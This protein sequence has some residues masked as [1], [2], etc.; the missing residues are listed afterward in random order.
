MTEERNNGMQP[1]IE[2]KLEGNMVKIHVEKD[3]T[4]SCVDRV[5]SLVI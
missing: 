1:Q 3:R 4:V 2:R 5:V